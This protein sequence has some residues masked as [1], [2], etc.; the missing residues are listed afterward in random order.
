MQNGPNPFYDVV[1]TVSYLL[2]K[3][4]LKFG[5][6]YAHIEAD[7]FSHDTRGRIEFK[8]KQLLSKKSTPLEDFFGGRPSGGR[9]LL[10]NAM[11]TLTWRNYAGSFR[12]TGASPRN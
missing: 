10:G 12:M 6:E 9:Q 5:G 8:G 11:R 7:S 3:H 1:D 2:G 4:T